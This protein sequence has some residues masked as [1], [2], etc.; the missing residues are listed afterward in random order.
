MAVAVKSLF[1]RRSLAL[2]RARFHAW[3]EGED[4]DEA[5][6]LA[7]IEGAAN[8]RDAGAETE[9]FEDPGYAPPPRLVA[10]AALWGESR[11]RPDGGAA[12]ALEPE[13]IGLATAGALAVVGPGHAAPV[14]AAAAAH[15]GKIDVFE[16]REETLEAL[17]H[18]VCK[19][20][21]GERVSVARIDLEALSLT[22]TAYDCLLSLDDFAYCAYPPHLAQQ[23]AKCLK[24]G[25][26]AIVECYVGFRAAELATA[27]ATA[28][29]EPQVRAHGDMLQFFKDA[30]FVIEADEDLTERLLESVRESFKRLSETL[31]AAGELDAAATREL[32]WEAEAWRMRLKLLSQRRLERRRFMLR[33]APAAQA[34]NANAPSA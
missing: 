20:A 28:F 19:A 16:W 34:G 10:L 5:A 31:T 1:D 27:F 6:A 9:L 23:I 33:R 21:L 18:G 29:A 7:A 17:K 12:D 11:I 4:F 8:D 32:A 30:G 26:C 22:P 25:G 24:P 3:W 15:P 2:A 13:R 14:L